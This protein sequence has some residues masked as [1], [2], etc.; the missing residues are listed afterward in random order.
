MTL[1]IRD[2]TVI[3]LAQTTHHQGDVTDDAFRG[4]QCPCS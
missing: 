2:Y 1:R 3:K 4:I